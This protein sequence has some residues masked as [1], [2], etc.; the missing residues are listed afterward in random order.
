V[1]Y[2]Y[3][4]VHLW[5]ALP[6]GRILCYPHAK[7][8]P[9]G[10]TYAKA[11]WKPSADATEWPRAR[12][13]KGLA[14]ENITQAVANDL[15]RHSLNLCYLQGLEVVLHCHDEIVVECSSKD[16]EKTIEHLREI[17]CVPPEWA[18]GVPLNIDIHSLKR[19]GK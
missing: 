18:K 15:L 6:S 5:Y 17:M 9:E 16:A 7:L 10:V 8:E 1:T 19:Y 3:D 12:L 14:C 11:A 2:L 13:W 4:G